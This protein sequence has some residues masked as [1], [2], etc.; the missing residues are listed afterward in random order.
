[1]RENITN[2]YDELMDVLLM[3][4]YLV[5]AMPTAKSFLMFMH[6]ELSCLV[7]RGGDWVDKIIEKGQNI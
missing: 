6:N 1:V 4:I 2:F 3:Y 5:Y 7:D